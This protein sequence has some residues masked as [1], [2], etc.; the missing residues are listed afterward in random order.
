MSSASASIK[1]LQKE[2]KAISQNNNE[3]NI[4]VKLVNDDLYHW[5]IEIGMELICQ[6]EETPLSQSFLKWRRKTKIDH[7]TFVAK[8]SD[9]Y[10]NHPPFIYLEQPTNLSG[11]PNGAICIST[12]MPQVWST[13]TQ[14]ESLMIHILVHL[15]QSFISPLTK[16]INTEQAA[17]EIFTKFLSI[18]KNDF[19]NN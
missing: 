4:T 3:N 1:R 16:A 17:N 10:P 8:F 6:L 5:R 13:D 12:L 14:I 18:H 2:Y 11:V 7:M 9:N 15:E 19:I